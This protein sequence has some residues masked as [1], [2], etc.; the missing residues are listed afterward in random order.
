[1]FQLGFETQTSYMGELNPFT[2]SLFS[3]YLAQNTQV[4][5]VH[6][7]GVTSKIQGK[8]ILVKDT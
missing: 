3:K 2:F 4:N 7:T 8:T 6:F 5:L 1:M